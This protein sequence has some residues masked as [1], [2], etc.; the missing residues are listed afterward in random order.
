[1]TEQDIEQLLKK[2]NAGECTPEEQLLLYNLYDKLDR[3]SAESGYQAPD[4]NFES[5]IWDRIQKDRQITSHS[6]T[7]RLYFRIAVAAACVVLVAGAVYLT[8]VNK[9]NSHE[10][11]TAKAEDVPAGSNRA[12]LTLAN[13]Q[14]IVLDAAKAGTLVQQAGV[15]VTK[16]ANGQLVYVISSDKTPS[17]V[18]TTIAYNTITTPNGGQYEIYLPDGSHVYLNAASSLKYPIRFIGDTRMV[19][20]KGEAYFEI[21]KINNQS[22]IVS[23]NGQSLKVLGTHFNVA[24]YPDE[25]IVTTLAEGKI[26]LSNTSFPQKTILQPGDQSTA[27]PDRFKI[28]KVNIDDIAAWKDGL[29]IFN[30]TSLKEVF[31]QLARW[32]DVSVDYSRI[33]DMAYEGEI[34][35]NV[36]LLKVLELI[37]ATSN[38]SFKLEGR[39]IMR[40]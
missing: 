35:R 9:N 15:T 24:S 34:P 2:Y 33:P 40:E 8:S 37:E 22:F 26:E 1:M 27:L 11:L 38:V 16:N 7:K 25:P 32:Y 31:K 36:G 29:F 13:G 39:R 10:V 17:G 19:M 28:D 5:I 23:S 14:Q 6:Y 3:E 21:R 18:G 4:E 12:T 20:L 30:N